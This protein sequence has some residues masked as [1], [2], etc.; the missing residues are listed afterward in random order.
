MD[1]IETKLK[2][3]FLIK[4]V[5][6]NDSRGLF[7]ETFHERQW[8]EAGLPIS[9]SFVQD[10][11]SLSKAYGTVRGLHYQVGLMSQAKVIRVVSGAVFDV[12]VD[13]RRG[14]P[15]FGQWVGVELSD[16]NRYQLFIPRGF[17]H[18]LCTLKANTEVLYKVD[19]HY[20]KESERGIAWNDPEL[21]IEWPVD[22]PILSEKDRYNPLFEAAD[23]DF[24]YN[25]RL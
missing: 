12:A 8:K 22:V 15:T 7:F 23:F 18:G 16:E 5:I 1:V 25:G 11:H 24:T 21:Q 6:Y 2:D 4:P 9:N 20:S 19:N 14:S 13:I 3:V 10:N 17:A